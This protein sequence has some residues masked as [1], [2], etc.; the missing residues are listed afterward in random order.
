[1]TYHLQKRHYQ[2]NRFVFQDAINHYYLERKIPNQ[3][4]EYPIRDNKLNLYYF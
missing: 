4:N 1:M 2:E 3:T